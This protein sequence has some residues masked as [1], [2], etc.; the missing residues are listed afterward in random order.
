MKKLKIRQ[1]VK[2]KKKTGYI[3]I[4]ITRTS[5]FE[6]Y[7]QFYAKNKNMNRYLTLNIVFGKLSDL[8]CKE[9]EER[10]KNV[11]GIHWI[12]KSKLRD[13]INIKTNYF[14]CDLIDKGKHAYTDDGKIINSANLDG[15]N[16]ENA[17]LQAKDIIK[18]F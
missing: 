8:T 4:E 14:V 10:F 17:R 13:F 1:I 3:N 15:F 12:E 18:H 16:R 6:V 2:F 11:E 7:S 5:I 9:V